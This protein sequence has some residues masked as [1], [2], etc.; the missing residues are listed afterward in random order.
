MEEA[1]STVLK[2]LRAE[3][4]LS[5]R[6]VGVAA[7]VDPGYISKLSKSDR[8]V[9]QAVAQALDAALGADGRL[10]SAWK[11]GNARRLAAR[12]T[13]EAM[14]RRTL[15][16]GTMGAVLGGLLPGRKEAGYRLG[17][18]DVAQIPRHVDRLFAMDYQFGG[19]SLWQVAVGYATE[20]RWW[21]ENGVLTGD[22]EEALLHA[23]SRVQ[24]CAGWLAFDAGRHDVARNSY[25]EALGL[26]R[27]AQDAEAETHAL[28]NL[29]FMSNVLGSPKEGRRWADAAERA[30]C[31]TDEHARLSIIPM[32]RVAMSS[33]LT[34]EKRSC[35]RAL[36][37]ARRYLER[38]E[39]RPVAEWLAFVT[40][41]EL[42]GIE[43]TCAMEL[44]E[45]D[46]SIRLFNE[47]ID[48]HPDGF[49]RNRATYK[50]RLALASL[51]AQEVEQAAAAAHS[52]LDDLSGNVTS[53][54]LSTELGAVANKMASHHTAPVAT[55]FVTRYRALV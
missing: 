49:A 3:S 4:G 25:H 24:M 19:E 27:Q 10:M 17:L 31:A 39:D 43:A 26:A 54:R 9:S 46:R 38:D 28:A 33:A 50:V 11:A 42:D 5:V 37:T 12:V 32:L 1:F 7:N 6:Q 48:A 2:R 13:S 18:S 16:A 34:G 30:A 29:A 55:N 8:G 21:L 47:S 15:M 20:A 41:H 53:W 51:D 14:K 52:A 22:V 35:E 40:W 36:S 23:T 44:G 45:T